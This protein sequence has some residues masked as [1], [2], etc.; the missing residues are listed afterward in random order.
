MYLQFIFND[1]KLSLTATSAQ[2]TLQ[3]SCTQSGRFYTLISLKVYLHQVHPSRLSHI[4]P[5]EAF[6]NVFL[7][8]CAFFEAYFL[9]T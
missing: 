5:S 2:L 9:Q 8:S 4:T 1:L 7:Y 6:Q 3:G